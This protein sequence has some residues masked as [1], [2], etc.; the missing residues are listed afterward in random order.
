MRPNNSRWG[1]WWRSKCFRNKCWEDARRLERFRREARV[2]ALLH[3]TNI[4]QV[5]GVGDEDGLSYY[6]MQLI[7]GVSLDRV[8]NQLKDMAA[9]N[10]QHGSGTAS[11]HETEEPRQFSPPFTAA[12]AARAV[13]DGGVEEWHA[14]DDQSFCSTA[15]RLIRKLPAV[16]SDRTSQPALPHVNG[17]PQQALSAGVS[18]GKP[19]LFHH[20]YWHS[21]AQIGVQ[22]GDA[23]QYAHAHGTLHRDI[24]PGNVLLSPKGTVWVTDFGVAKV[25]AQEQL[26]WT[27]DVV[28]TLRYMPPEQLDG[29]CDARSDVYSLG[30][31]LYELL[32]LCPAF[33]E[34]SE[35]GL[36]RRKLNGE[37]TLPRKVQPH[38]LR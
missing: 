8:I 1:D 12:D 13:L 18:L 5:F 22:V 28:G 14:T 23:L 6:V 24:K 37:P 20:G 10:G 32:T 38:I 16:E 2:A 15:S 33:S 9:G 27:G 30:L 4:V 11:A 36:I 3:H 26:S 35:D 17:N 31:T 21:V 7:R 25:V 29:N 34:T 19:D